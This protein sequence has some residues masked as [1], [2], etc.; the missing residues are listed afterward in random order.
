M[1][2]TGPFLGQ[3]K[4]SSRR[5]CEVERGNKVFLSASWV[6]EEAMEKF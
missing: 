3:M 4:R 6:G 2:E 5:P 1:M